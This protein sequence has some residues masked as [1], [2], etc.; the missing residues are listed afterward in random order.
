MRSLEGQNG[1][2][3]RYR[4]HGCVETGTSLEMVAASDGAYTER[5]VH[6]ECVAPQKRVCLTHLANE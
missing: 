1:R 5:V 3:L 6:H 4:R 2:R